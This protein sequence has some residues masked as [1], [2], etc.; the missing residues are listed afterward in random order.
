M[1]SFGR[2]FS[3]RAPLVSSAAASPHAKR[4]LINQLW[5]SGSALAASVEPQP[6]FLELDSQV[7]ATSSEPQTAGPTRL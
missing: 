3:R 5:A 2:S 1:G 7:T 4:R 6:H